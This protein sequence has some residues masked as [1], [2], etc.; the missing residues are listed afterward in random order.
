MQH[1]TLSLLLDLDH[2]TVAQAHRSTDTLSIDKRTQRASLI[3]NYHAATRGKNSGVVA[4]YAG[5]LNL[6]LVLTAAPDRK[7]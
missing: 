4:R 3:L 2:I 5:L 1:R 6:K 7:S